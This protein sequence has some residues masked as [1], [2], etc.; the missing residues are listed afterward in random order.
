MDCLRFLKLITM[1]LTGKCKVYFEKWI[2][3]QKYSIT[4]DV[5]ERQMNIV[6]LG[7]MFNQLPTS[8]KYGVYL[9]FF[10]SLDMQIYIKPTMSNKWSVYIDFFGHHILTDYLTKD[11]RQEARTEVIKKANEIY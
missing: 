8:M 3:K 10:D 6:N 11:T 9:D 5:G 1:E 7:S 4:H 2:S